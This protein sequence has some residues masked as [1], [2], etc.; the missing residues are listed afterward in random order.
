MA[1]QYK[2]LVDFHFSPEEERFYQTGEISTL[3][4]WTKKQI[5][6]AVGAGLIAKVHDRIKPDTGGK[7]DTA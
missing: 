3:K 4:G 7:K 2:V 1:T 6:S 5:S